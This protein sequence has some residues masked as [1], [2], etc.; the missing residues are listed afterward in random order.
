MRFL[1][2][3]IPPAWPRAWPLAWLLACAAAPAGFGQ[4]L[5]GQAWVEHG[6]TK[7]DQIRKGRLRVIVHDQK[8]RPVSGAPVRLRMVKHDFTFGVVVDGADLPEPLRDR[9]NASPLWRAINAV[10]FESL[11][12]WK[13]VSPTPGGWEIDAVREAMFNAERLGLRPAW[14]T[15][16]DPR[17]AARPD[18][19]EKIIAEHG[20]A[21]PAVRQHVARVGSQFGRRT[22][23]LIV[24]RE[25]R[26]DAEPAAGEGDRIRTLDQDEPLTGR[27][28]PRQSP[29]E[30]D[31]FA[32]PMSKIRELF[33]LARANAPTARLAVRF[34]NRLQG[35]PMVQL[36][37]RLRAYQQQ[38]IPIDTVAVDLARSDPILHGRFKESLDWVGRLDARLVIARLAIGGADPASAAL[39][40]ETV[41]R[42]LF[43]HPAVDGVFFALR[44][45][46]DQAT[47]QT[48]HKAANQATNQN[49]GPA[50]DGTENRVRDA[51]GGWPPHAGLLDRQGRLTDAGRVVES[52]LTER[53][54]TDRTMATDARGE[55]RA[56]VFAGVYTLEVLLPD[57]RRLRSSCTVLPGDEDRVLLLTP[58]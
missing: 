41:L 25:R 49:K 31:P 11:T 24:L 19:L 40:L 3:I 21:F 26:P 33:E 58:E 10:R 6:K 32:L 20:G 44:P 12:A 13:H 7:I 50:I 4:V 15:A 16:Y 34:T 29:Q 17:P 9:S 1:R 39:H 27:P 5:D 52:L 46:P 47:D 35:P 51:P 36:R 28:T 22:G 37:A 48:T 38:L 45:P 23:E 57:G 56:R 55:L 18:W 42:S 2:S 43:A 53:W 30:G 8:G 54:W 14:S